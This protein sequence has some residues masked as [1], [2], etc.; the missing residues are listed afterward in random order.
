MGKWIRIASGNMPANGKKVW[1]SFTNEIE[2]YVKVATYVNGK[3]MHENGHPVKDKPTAWQ[4]YEVPA[5][6]EVN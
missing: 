6:Y 5:P 3:F 2:S 4:P 1:L